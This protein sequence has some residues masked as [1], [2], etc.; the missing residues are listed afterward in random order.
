MYFRDRADA[1]RRLAAE[2]ARYADRP[3]V[4]VLALPRG[5]VPVGYEVAASLRAPVTW[6]AVQLDRLRILGLLRLSGSGPD[7]AYVYEPANRR[8]AASAEAL[9]A[10]FR[11]DRS[12]V[13]ALVLGTPASPA[14]AFSDAFRV[15][16][17]RREG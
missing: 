2:L 15:S 13:A 10:A 11:S 1:G 7:T 12:A 5:G 17:R 9:L 14:Q 3:D 8:L 16:R 6:A 4:L